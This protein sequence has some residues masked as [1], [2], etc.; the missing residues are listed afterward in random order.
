MC[1]SFVLRA[2]QGWFECSWDE[3][4]RPIPSGLE[5]SI[6]QHYLD[7]VD[8]ILHE[9]A[10]K[11]QM[12]FSGKIAFPPPEFWSCVLDVLQACD[13]PRLNFRSN[14]RFQASTPSMSRGHLPTWAAAMDML[15]VG[16]GNS[17]AHTDALAVSA[18]WGRSCDRPPFAVGV[19]PYINQT[20]WPYVAAHNVILSHLKAV[21]RFKE[22]QVRN[23]KGVGVATCDTHEGRRDEVVIWEPQKDSCTTWIL[24]GNAALCCREFHRDICVFH[25]SSIHG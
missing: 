22:L 7:Y 11:V 24:D 18:V 3:E 10:G 5:S 17:L 19:A 2:S 23:Q 6:S 21:M 8:V 12:R 25:A 4:G 9:F 16:P 15:Q 20:V 14:P 1:L 13:I